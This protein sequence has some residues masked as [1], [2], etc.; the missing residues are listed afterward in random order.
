MILPGLTILVTGAN[1][2]LGCRLSNILIKRGYGV[3][4]VVRNKERCQHIQDFLDQKYGTEGQFELFEVLDLT[5][6]GGPL[7]MPLRVSRSVLC[8]TLSSMLTRAGC[9]G[10]VH[11]AVD[12][13][14]SPDTTVVVD[15]SVALTLRALEAAASERGLRCFVLK[16]SY[17]AAC[18][19]HMNEAYDIKQA[20]WNDDYVVVC[21][22]GADGRQ[23]EAQDGQ[24]G[25]KE[26]SAVS[27]GTCVLT[28]RSL[29]CLLGLSL[30]A[31]S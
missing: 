11:L 19:Y 22:E 17:I 16:L 31:F 30:F 8:S 18:Q 20:S 2:Y 24:R 14:F 29:A 15:G 26:G 13:G 21:P 6:Q 25:S 28:D 12:N 7:T 9:A 3:R 5:K 10:F 1:G 23:E 4:G 27:H